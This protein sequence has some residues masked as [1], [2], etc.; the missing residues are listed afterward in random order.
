MNLSGVL[1]VEIY[2]QSDVRN[3]SQEDEDYKETIRLEDKIMNEQCDIQG[4]CTT[5]A[6]GDCCDMPEKLL[7]LADEAWYELLKEKIKAEI[8]KSCGVRLDK[9][10]NFIA[11]TN[12]A[13]WEHEFQGKLKCEEY[14][15]NLM[16]LFS[17]A[18]D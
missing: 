13:K 3:S 5:E 4:S 7:A 6:A 1:F 12:K 17:E 10:A 2:K 14:K 8:E 18:C 16:A 15:Q 11:E 9:L